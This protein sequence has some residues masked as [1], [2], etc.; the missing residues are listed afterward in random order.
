M[1]RRG[2]IPQSDLKKIDMKPY[3]TVFASKYQKRADKISSSNFIKT[4]DKFG[5]HLRNYSKDDILK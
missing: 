4:Q 1:S 3:E 2:E 5:R